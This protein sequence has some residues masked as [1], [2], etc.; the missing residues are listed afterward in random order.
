M[1]PTSRP[2][3]PSTDS[4]TRS[5]ARRAVAVRSRPVDGR[6]LVTRRILAPSRCLPPPRGV[7]SDGGDWW[8]RQASYEV[9]DQP[10]PPG[11]VRGTQAAP[12]VAVEVL[13]EQRYRPAR[14]RAEPGVVVGRLAP[15]RA[16]QEQRDE[17]V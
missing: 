5:P 12:V 9:G 15:V 4:C 1:R 8:Q 13:E 10:C 17:P 14:V 3:S 2:K 7:R 16:G 6:S 11:L